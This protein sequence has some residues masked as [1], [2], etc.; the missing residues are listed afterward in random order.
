MKKLA[1]TLALTMVLAGCGIKAPLEPTTAAATLPT[2]AVTP[3][4]PGV[5]A[6]LAPLARAGQR[7]PKQEDFLAKTKEIGSYGTLISDLAS[8]QAP[9]DNEVE[10]T[11]QT[12][13]AAT[14]EKADQI[15]HQ[16]STDAKQFY[17]G[18]GFKH[19]S[20]FGRSRHV[21][22]SNSRK[23][24]Y[25]VDFNFWGTKIDEYETSGLIIKYAG[26]L[27][28]EVLNQPQDVY[29]VT[30]RKAYNLAREFGWAAPT[31]GSVKVLLISPILVGPQWVFLDETNKPAALVD[32]TSGTV[33]T[34]GWLLTA[35][36]YL[37]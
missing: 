18:W 10:Q 17:L 27:I 5:Q 15:A 36:Y 24:L 34:G 1:A 21:Y 25:T 12:T 13:P 4:F 19:I 7:E 14:Q 20:F 35:L 2:N 29:P 37:F 30:G 8:L 11:V 22:F 32:A 23:S 9:T 26:K 28:A 3:A 16:W 33:Q 6:P 31:M